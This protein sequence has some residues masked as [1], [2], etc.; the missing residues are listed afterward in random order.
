[1]PEKA[2]SMLRCLDDQEHAVAKKR[3]AHAVGDSGW[4][5]TLGVLLLDDRPLPL[6][7]LT[8]LQFQEK[9]MGEVMEPLT[10]TYEAKGLEVQAKQSYEELRK[11]MQ[12]VE[13]EE[14][15]KPGADSSGLDLAR[16]E[17]V[18][19]KDEGYGSGELL[20]DRPSRSFALFDN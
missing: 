12:E 3:T 2:R 10:A 16:K 8:N 7:K 1:M 19:K 6:L 14:E 11:Q 15:K 18:S 9:R 17:D 20:Y 4:L 5:D 13:E